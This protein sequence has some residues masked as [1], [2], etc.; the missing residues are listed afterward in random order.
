MHDAN[1]YYFT[2]FL[3]SSTVIYIRK[4]KREFIV[5]SQMEVER[6]KKESRV[7][8]VRSTTDYGVK[9][10]IKKYQDPKR[11]RCELLYKILRE[12][13][14]EQIEVPGNFPFFLSEGLRKKGTNIT[15]AEGLEKVREVKSKAEI[16]CIIRAQRACEK[17]MRAAIDAIKSAKIRGDSLDITSER[18]KFII[19]HSLIDGQCA[20]DDIIVA[21][22]K[23]AS[24][25]HCKGHGMLKKDASI[26]ID[27]FP[28]HRRGRYHADMSR[29]VLRGEATAE[30]TDMY[31]AV[32]DAQNVA[33]DI[34]KAGVTG[35]D[36][37]N[38]VCDLFEGRGYD[39]EMKGSKTGFI[40]STGHGVG[41]EIHE[42]P[43]LSM[44]GSALRAGNVITVEPGLYYPNIGGVRVEDIVLVTAKGYKNLTKFPKQLVI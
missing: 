44:G 25:P 41:I 24:N 8:D 16:E 40:H 26:V 33:F 1:L 21:C 39:T 36:V 27:V 34:I 42:G 43:S 28:Y 11:V 10:L 5:L 2:K 29:T 14:V 3:T 22:G 17:A 23:Q 18:V 32:L 30:I 15:L 4:G 13:G 20:T 12:E 19:E 37:H 7:K 31:Q 38:A 35:E 6:A 9:E